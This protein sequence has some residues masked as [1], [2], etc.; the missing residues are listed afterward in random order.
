MAR[1]GNLPLGDTTRAEVALPLEH[2][3][4]EEVLP[5]DSSM[6]DNTPHFHFIAY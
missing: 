4:F 3:A 1:E 2:E 5:V 6:D